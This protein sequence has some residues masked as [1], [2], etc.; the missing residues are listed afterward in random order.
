MCAR[1]IDSTAHV[2]SN[3]RFDDPILAAHPWLVRVS[4]EDP[5]LAEPLLYALLA[6]ARAVHYGGFDEDFSESAT[7]IR[8]GDASLEQIE[9]GYV[10]GE[11]AHKEAAVA[12]AEYETAADCALRARCSHGCGSTRGEQ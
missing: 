7:A 5:S 8:C 12:L 10:K 2:T 1:R 4:D 11:H 3:R 9:E 6:R